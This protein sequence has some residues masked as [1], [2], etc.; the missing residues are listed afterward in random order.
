MMT[1]RKKVSDE[2][3]IESYSKTQNVWKTGEEVGMCGQ[4]VHERLT[5]LGIINKMNY[6]TEND[7]NALVEK[8]TRY[9]L[10][11]RLDELAKELGRT[12]QFICRKA[13][14]LGL[15]DRNLHPMAD[16]AKNKLS[17]KTKEWIRQKGH[18][19]G[20][21][22]HKHN[23]EARAKISESSKKT[24][25][26]PNSI[27]NSEVNR[28]RLSDVLHERQMHGNINKY[29]IWGKH[30]VDF[31]NRTYVFKSTWEVEIAKQLQSMQDTGII[32][33]WGY[34]TKHFEFKDIQR[35]IR[36]YC[37]DFEVMLPDGLIFY[38]E[39]KGWKMFKS[40][41]RI[42]MFRERY[43]NIKLILLDEKEYKNVLESD[44]N[45]ILKYIK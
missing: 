25:R 27:L 2:A 22:G 41:K 35:G 32:T 29:S 12:K 36:S 5:K 6:W 40:M 13:K 4:S 16:K 39:V 34:E 28:Q 1:S 8:Y 11:N 3:L 44:I 9:K 45:W 10:E 20:Y 33:H 18:P 37:P 30:K 31:A 23:D 42:Q 21:L 19:K 17:I 15:T 14:I 26:D 38:I 24:W 43:P 7:D